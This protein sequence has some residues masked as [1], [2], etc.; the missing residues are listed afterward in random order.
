MC[1]GSAPA[2]M[3]KAARV[4]GQCRRCSAVSGPPH[5][6]H[7]MTAT[8]GSAACTRVDVI[9]PFRWRRKRVHRWAWVAA[10]GHLEK[11]CRKEAEFQP[12]SCI[13]LHR[14]EMS[15]TDP[16]RKWSFRRSLPQL[17]TACNL[18]FFACIHTSAFTKETLRKLDWIR[19]Q[20]YE[21]LRRRPKHRFSQ[22][23]TRHTMHKQKYAKPAQKSNFPPAR[24][25]GPRA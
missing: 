17:G 21:Q 11:P 6:G 3:L 20:L 7:G 18:R 8:A 5:R 16:S 4:T 15:A 24:K 14:W 9:S 22:N 23:H 19:S 25:S 1:G 10:R 13:R 2:A 12:L